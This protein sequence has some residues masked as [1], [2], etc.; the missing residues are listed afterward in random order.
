M[1]WETKI[2]N[3]TDEPFICCISHTSKWEL[4][5]YFLYRYDE[6]LR[7]IKIVMKPQPFKYYGWILRKFGF[8]PSTKREDSGNGF[9]ANTIEMLKDEKIKHL[10]ISPEGTLTATPWRSGYF[11]IAKG[12]NYPIGVSGFDFEKKKLIVSKE[13][14]IPENIITTEPRIKNIMGKIVPLYEEKSFVAIRK[15][16]KDNVGL[17]NKNIFYYGIPILIFATK[18][19][20]V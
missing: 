4:L 3:I 2:K 12:I 19:Y 16:T 1:G 14:F 6:K 15:H 13:K 17:L 9:V 8:V 18:Y 5:L 11:Y 7:N 20:L 10:A